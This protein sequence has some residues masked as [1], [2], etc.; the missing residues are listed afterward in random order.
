LIFGR[1]DVHFGLVAAALRS[2]AMKA[3]AVELVSPTT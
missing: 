2:K 3:L 1:S